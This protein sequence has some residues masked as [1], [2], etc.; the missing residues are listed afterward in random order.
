MSY[1]IAFIILI[2]SLCSYVIG[3][4]ESLYRVACVLAL[5]PIAYF[6]FKNHS[7]Y[8]YLFVS[9]LCLFTR[10]KPLAPFML[11]LLAFLSAA[12]LT[13][14]LEL[15]VIYSALML[16]GPSLRGQ[17][18]RS[19][20]F[21]LALGV[22]S[23]LVIGQFESLQSFA[24]ASLFLPVVLMVIWNHLFLLLPITRVNEALDGSI[25]FRMFLVG[26]LL[27]LKI[28]P[29]IGESIAYISPELVKMSLYATLA[30]TLVYTIWTLIKSE[31]SELNNLLFGLMRL[32]VLI[33]VWLGAETEVSNHLLLILFLELIG[34]LLAHGID[35]RSRRAFATTTA[36]SFGLRL[37]CV[38]Y[39]YQFLFLRGSM[40]SMVASYLS[41]HNFLQTDLIWRVFAFSL[42]PAIL[43]SALVLILKM[44]QALLARR[45]SERRF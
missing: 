23:T 20:D 38:G 39:I 44:N 19:L 5:A 31:R 14:E 6:T 3:Q 24:L 45:P 25:V 34:R 2:F 8:P 21:I 27:P 9:T 15:L 12:S 40:S 16:A 43:V 28:S 22:V 11:A 29:I 32:L 10:E 37:V 17:H 33:P 4:R 18:M 36:A 7:L 1:E 35:L 30:M 13:L 26:Y 42:V 41:Q